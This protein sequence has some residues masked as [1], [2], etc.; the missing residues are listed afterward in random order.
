MSLKKSFSNE[1]LAFVSAYALGAVI[2]PKGRKAVTLSADGELAGSG[3]EETPEDTEELKTRASE[4]VI[5]S[6]DH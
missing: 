1:F 2:A 3:T 5:G 6:C 4:G